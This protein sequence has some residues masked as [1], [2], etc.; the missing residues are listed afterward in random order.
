MK[1]LNK[2]SISKCEKIR[3]K[4]QICS[5]LQKKSTIKNFIFCG[6]ILI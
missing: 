1:F 4:L 5:Y 3:G 6:V 2:D